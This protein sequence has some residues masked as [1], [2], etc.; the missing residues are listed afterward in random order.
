MIPEILR[1]YA[2]TLDHLRRLVADVPDADLARQPAGVVNHPAWV[3]GHLT[4]SCQAIGEELGLA[5][6]LP[7]DWESRFGTGSTP[8]GRRGAYPSKDEL[9]AA[10]ADGQRRVEDGLRALGE[11]GLARPLP[12]ARYRA[13]FPTIGDAALHVLT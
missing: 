5:A 2:R 13:A 11:D 1:G 10:L 7:A 6:W 8:V 12:D 4:H 9:L 3:I